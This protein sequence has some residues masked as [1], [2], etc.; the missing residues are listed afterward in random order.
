MCV[1]QVKPLLQVT[2]QDEEIQS[3]EAELQKAKD[4]LGRVELDYVELDRKHTQVDLFFAT[5]ISAVTQ[6][7]SVCLCISLPAFLDL[8]SVVLLYACRLTRTQMGIRV[9]G[10]L[11]CCRQRSLKGSGLFVVPLWSK[12]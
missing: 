9:V 1:F 6:P 2:R 4:N 8:I 3:R 5:L 7:Q 11:I 12:L 10:C